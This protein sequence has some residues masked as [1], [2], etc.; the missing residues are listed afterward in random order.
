MR[1]V[2]T[3]SHGVADW[4][5]GALLIVLPWLLGRRGTPGTRSRRR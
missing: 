3:R 4:L 2:P 5:V 1:F